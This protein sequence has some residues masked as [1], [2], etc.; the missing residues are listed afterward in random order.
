MYCIPG[1]RQHTNMTTFVFTPMTGLPNK[2]HFITHSVTTTA[3][4]I[5]YIKEHTNGALYEAVLFEE[6]IDV[7]EKDLLADLRKKFDLAMPDVEEVH[8]ATS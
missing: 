5:L 4:G 3:V 1:S 7:D 6:G 8:V 2:P